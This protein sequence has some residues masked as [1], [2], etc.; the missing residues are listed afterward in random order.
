[1]SARGRELSDRM[2][3]RMS[4]QLASGGGAGVLFRNRVLADDSASAAYGL[5]TAQ[6]F[7]RF[8]ASRPVWFTPTLV[9]YRDL[10]LHNEPETWRKPELRYVPG[11]VRDAEELP[12]LDP[13]ATA[14][15][16]ERG[17]EG[18]RRAKASFTALVNAGAKFLAGTDAPVYPV[19]P[20]FSLH[21]ELALLREIGLTPLG[22]LQAATRN[23]A[24]A[25]G[26]LDEVGTIEVGKSADLV[27]L[28][29]DPLADLANTR[30]IDAVV[31]RGRL[32]DRGTLDR[33]LG[34]AEVFARSR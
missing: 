33:M 29:A 12:R 30:A 17:R 5:A 13:N 10:M 14:A 7:A 28:D 19:V 18:W 6:E 15:D 34:D 22:A 21:E 16:R 20:G 8:A 27:L 24:E 9:V 2:L 32:L 11:V 3:A 31:T 23:A 25:A 26:L 1:N 4:E